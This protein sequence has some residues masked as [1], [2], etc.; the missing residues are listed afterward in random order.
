MDRQLQMIQHLAEYRT[1]LLNA[2][3]ESLNFFDTDYFYLLM[4]PISWAVLGKKFGS[5]IVFMIMLSGIV[6]FFIKD[7][8]QIPRPF[9]IDPSIGLIYAPGYSFPSGAAQGTVLI[10]G[11][12]Y[13]EFRKKWMIPI[14]A[15]YILLVSFSRNYLG[16]HY[17]IDILGGWIVGGVLL[18]FYFFVYLK[19]EKPFSKM[20]P[21][22]PCVIRLAF[23]TLPLWMSWDPVYVKISAIAI[24]VSVGILVLDYLKKDVKVD[25]RWSVNIIRAFCSCLLLVFL[26]LILKK[27][28]IEQKEIKNI[29][30]YFTLGFTETFG[31]ICLASLLSFRS[32]KKR[33]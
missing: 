27:V 19:L 14:L 18:L 10:S 29:I 6:N 5:R 24:G 23:Y 31:I 4:I 16:V 13:N 1:P 2:F 12:L 21:G 30:I 11:I 3:F 33:S 28:N 25:R 22:Y 20:R 8:F 7:I 26:Y 15:A 9:T 17:P 32:S